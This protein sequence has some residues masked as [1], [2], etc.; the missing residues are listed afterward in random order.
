M[1]TKRDISIG[2]I[3]GCQQIVGHLF[4]G[5]TGRG[6]IPVRCVGCEHEKT[7]DVYDLTRKGRHPSCKRCGAGKTN[8]PKSHVGERVGNLVVIDE[9]RNGHTKNLVA[10]LEC[11]NC[12]SHDRRLYNVFK[13]SAGMCKVCARVLTKKEKTEKYTS[14]MVLKKAFKTQN[15]KEACNKCGISSWGEYKLPMQ[16]D[17][18]IPVSKGG[19][20]DINNL[21]YLCPNCHAIKTAI[22]HP[23]W[24]LERV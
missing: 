21:Q 10:I 14:W 23:T 4:I 11:T 20:M 2:K 19:A 15:T 17:H 1:K 16:V 5:E 9:I 12:G 18:I 22:D 13:R 8:L 24:E 3:Y 7:Y 6:R